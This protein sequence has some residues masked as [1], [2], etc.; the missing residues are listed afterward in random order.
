MECFATKVN[1][2]DPLTI[3]A[4]PNI[5]PSR[6]YLVKINSRNTR[7]GCEICS[8]LKIKTLASFWFLIVNFEHISH[9]V[10]V[11]LLGTFNMQFPAGYIFVGI[12]RICLL[13]PKV[14][15]L[16][17]MTYTIAKKLASKSTY[18][19]SQNM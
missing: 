14:D 7:A 13:P 10:L 16:S 15:L 11:F 3:V 9:L 8:E 2:F 12:L 5:L 18:F 17:L 19:E 1:D 6:I 4:S